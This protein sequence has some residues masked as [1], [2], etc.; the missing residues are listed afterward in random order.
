NHYQNFPDVTSV[1]IAGRNLKA[2][3]RVDSAPANCA[4]PLTVEFFIADAGQ[5]R[6]F[7]YRATYTTPQALDNIV[8]KPVVLPA[9][10][11]KIVATATDAHGNTSEFSSPV[12]VA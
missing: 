3:Y 8:F 10:S 11:D 9:L 4:Y 12:A 7:I 2:E 5:G 6:T 1:K